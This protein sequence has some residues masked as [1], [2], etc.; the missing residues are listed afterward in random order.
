MEKRERL[1]EVMIKVFQQEIQKLN[2][3]LQSI[4]IDD[5]VTVFYN[6]LAVLKKIEQSKKMQLRT[7]NSLV[8]EPKWLT[9]DLKKVFNFK[10]N[11]LNNGFR[12]TKLVSKKKKLM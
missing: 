8:R 3:E 1:Q 9:E 10:V 2:P 5:M 6:R 4:L 11:I 7:N 12:L